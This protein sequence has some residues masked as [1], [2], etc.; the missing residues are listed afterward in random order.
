MRLAMCKKLL[1][2]LLL[3]VACSKAPS[4][5]PDCR[6]LL[7]WMPNPNHVALYAGLEKGIFSKHGIELDILRTYDCDDAFPFLATGRVEL[8]LCTMP[9]A[10]RAADEGY[11]IRYVA[12]LFDR[13]LV[14]FIARQDLG[15]ESFEDLH[16]RSLGA[17]FGMF[18]TAL[19]DCAEQHYGLAF[20]ERR[21]IAFDL[22]PALTTGQVD[23]VTGAFWNIEAEQLKALGVPISVFKVDDMGVPQYHNVVVVSHSN[24]SKRRAFQDAL[25]ESLDFCR[26]YPEEAFRLYLAANPEKGQSVRAWEEK[27]WEATLPLLGENSPPDAALWREVWAWMSRYGC[28]LRS[29]VFPEQVL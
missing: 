28:H 12:S 13:P 26:S 19:V 9:M 3:L 22:V 21:K 5:K 20:S 14:A 15:I 17:G 4:K 6:L 23:V 7:D 27:A 18:T 11:P 16:G 25:E 10:L 2:I 29:E 8:A 1:F 24:F